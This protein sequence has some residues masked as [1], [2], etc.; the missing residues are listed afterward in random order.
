M[1]ASNPL[2]VLSYDQ[3]QQSS[4][5]VVSYPQNSISNKGK[6]FVY[7]RRRSSLSSSTSSSGE[8][9]SPRSFKFSL[10]KA[11]SLPSLSVSCKRDE[12]LQSGKPRRYPRRGSRSASMLQ[13]ASICAAAQVAAEEIAANVLRKNYTFSLSNATT[14]TASG[15]DETQSMIRDNSRRIVSPERDFSSDHSEDDASISSHGS[16][17]LAVLTEALKLSEIQPPPKNP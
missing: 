16:R 13:S 9:T 7:P 15:K 12:L 1:T 10:Q 17:A 11:S 3:L 2:H 5:C 6:K 14:D 8:F 4:V